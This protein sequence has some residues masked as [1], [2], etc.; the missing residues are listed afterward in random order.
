MIFLRNTFKGYMFHCVNF[1]YFSLYIDLFYHKIVRNIYIKFFSI[2][3][4]DQIYTELLV[5]ASYCAQHR[6]DK[7]EQKKHGSILWG[8]SNL[9][10]EI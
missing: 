10:G 2:L 7:G 4:N 1:L 3:M 5:C 8:V 6:R 9:A